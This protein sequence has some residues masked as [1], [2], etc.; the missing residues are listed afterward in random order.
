M[1]RKTIFS[2]PPISI[3]RVTCQSLNINTRRS[4]S[5]DFRK[6]FSIPKGFGKFYPKSGAEKTA[7]SAA[8]QGATKGNSTGGGGGSNG[9]GSSNGPK[10]DFPGIPNGDWRS[11]VAIIAIALAS[12]MAFSGDGKGAR[13]ATFGHA[14]TTY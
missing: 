4:Y 2:V 3:S 6:L 5:T 8:Q 9:G 10:Q 12:L 1:F 7:E 11:S 14:A 13:Y